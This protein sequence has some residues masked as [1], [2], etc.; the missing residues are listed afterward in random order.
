LVFA[1]IP[2]TTP[3]ETITDPDQATTTVEPS[4]ANA[5]T[6]IVVPILP[7]D[8]PNRIYPA[9]QLSPTTDFTGFT[10]IS[11]LFNQ[12]L[13]W[14][15]VV[16]SQ[17]SMSQIFAYMPFLSPQRSVSQVSFSFHQ[18]FELRST[19]PNVDLALDS[20]FLLR[21]PSRFGRQRQDANERFVICV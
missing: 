12:E 1:S 16:G 8:I 9:D 15:F 21:P 4:A 19:M 5:A 11:I 13:N 7:T 3:T 17:I 14:P 6:T 18:I 20:P 2:T 10:L